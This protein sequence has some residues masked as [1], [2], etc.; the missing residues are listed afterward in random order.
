MRRWIVATALT[1]ALSVP[2]IAAPAAGPR[3][4]KVAAP[5]AN[6]ERVNVTVQL[7]VA[8][9]S[10]PVDP[11]L[12]SVA[13]QLR[14]LGLA[15]VRR[16]TAESARVSERGVV[17]AKVDGRRMRVTLI[18]LAPDTAKVDL[19]ASRDGEELVHQVYTA[20]R[21]KVGA[22]AGLGAY[23]GGKLFAAV[24]VGR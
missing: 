4:A 12:E 23:R 7:V 6:A 21:G 3:A 19:L 1:L 5:Q 14:S 24:T 22:L 8:R 9:E 20:P 16:V 15:S 10:G 13:R 18:S 11:G 2:A 17:V